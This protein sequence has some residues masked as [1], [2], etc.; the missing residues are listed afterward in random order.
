MFDTNYI[1]YNN[2]TQEELQT[3]SKHSKLKVLAKQQYLCTQHSK[4]DY[5]FNLASGTAVIERISC[6]GRRQVLAFIFPGDF[7][8]LSDSDHLDYAVKSLTDITAHQFSTN[9]LETLSTTIPRLEE[10][11]KNIRGKVLARVLGC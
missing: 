5:V 2:L 11:M 8:G 1:L 4:A 6:D 7:I 3:L 9:T 10:N